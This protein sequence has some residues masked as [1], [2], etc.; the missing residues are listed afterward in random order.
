MTGVLLCPYVTEGMLPRGLWGW[1]HSLCLWHSP[2]PPFHHTPVGPSLLEIWMLLECIT[3]AKQSGWKMRL[4]DKK[5]CPGSQKPH[6]G[7]ISETLGTNNKMDNSQHSLDHN[8]GI[9]GNGNIFLAM[10]QVKINHILQIFNNCILISLFCLITDKNH[11]LWPLVL[12][13]PLLA[14]TSSSLI[15]L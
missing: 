10:I 6:W 14:I 13:K 9:C 4:K 1:S 12:D 7:W 11:M 2:L 3:I 8:T 15:Y 5:I